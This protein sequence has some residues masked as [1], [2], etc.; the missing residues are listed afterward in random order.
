L[1]VSIMLFIQESLRF[2]VL[3][4]IMKVITFLGNTGMIW[5]ITGI[6]LLIH[7]KYRLV[8]FQVLITLAICWCL[9]D[10]VIKNLVARPRPYIVIENLEILIPEPSHYSF[11]SGHACSS[12][13]S[14]YVLAR[15]FGKKGAWFYVL[16][17]LIAISR[18]YVGVHYVSD[19]LA[20]MLLGTAGSFAIDLCLK[21]FIYP[22][23]KTKTKQY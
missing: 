15:N 4:S 23:F 10:L 12:F 17:V 5:I 19:I 1:D 21:N 20:G 6:V 22:K 8:G 7:K 11:P 13:A 9:N 16:A 14:A 3:D 2:P 18:P